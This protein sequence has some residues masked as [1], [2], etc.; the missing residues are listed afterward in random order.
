[1]LPLPN[2]VTFSLVEGRPYERTTQC[3]PGAKAIVSGEATKE[4]TNLPSS[5]QP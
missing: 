4:V 1:M 2:L 3:F 5:L